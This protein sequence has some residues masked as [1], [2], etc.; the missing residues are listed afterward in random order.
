MD[1]NIPQIENKEAQEIRDGYKY[2]IFKRTKSFPS[3]K[4]RVSVDLQ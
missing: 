1:K 4:C 2:S 3:T